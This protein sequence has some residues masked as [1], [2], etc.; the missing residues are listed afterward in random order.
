MDY[1]TSTDY[2]G[3]TEEKPAEYLQK[4]IDLV[5][6]M[7]MELSILYNFLDDGPDAG[8]VQHRFS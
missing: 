7:D 1:P 3:I 6:N 4:Q 2:Y 5:T 8:H